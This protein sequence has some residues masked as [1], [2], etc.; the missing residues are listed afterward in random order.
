MLDKLRRLIPD[1][2]ANKS[3]RVLD[4]GLRVYCIE[5]AREPDGL[6]AGER[7]HYAIGYYMGIQAGIAYAGEWGVPDCVKDTFTVLPEA[8]GD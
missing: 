7:H 3:G 2:E 4:D 1:D 8:G 6:T 5:Q